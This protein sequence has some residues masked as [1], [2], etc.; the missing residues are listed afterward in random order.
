[1]SSLDID[2]RIFALEQKAK[3]VSN[4]LRGLR[5]I[6]RFKD[7]LESHQASQEAN[8]VTSNDHQ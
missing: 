3:L 4:Q 1:M 7:R 8:D 5:M 2:R 6:K